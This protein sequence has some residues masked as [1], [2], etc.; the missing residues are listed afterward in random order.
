MITAIQP[1]QANYTTS[2]LAQIWDLGGGRARSCNRRDTSN[3]P[4]PSVS[5]EAVQA[6][7]EAGEVSALDASSL[8]DGHARSRMPSR[9]HVAHAPTCRSQSRPAARPVRQ[10][11][12]AVLARALQAAPASRPA[13][14]YSRQDIAQY[15]PRL[16]PAT[17]FAQVAR[18][19]AR[20]LKSAT[21]TLLSNQRPRSGHGPCG[22]LPGRPNA[23]TKTAA[24]DS[25][26]GPAT[27]G[28]PG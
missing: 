1:E 24:R 21:P 9:R 6:D 28:E 2:S 7:G 20:V 23:T 8:I 5:G 10:R 17:A 12:S 14:L 25:A 16:P 11:P 18:A 27:A 26:P 15:M 4:V 13:R 3:F 22:Y 19:K